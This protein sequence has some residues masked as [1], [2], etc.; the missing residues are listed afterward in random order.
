MNARP[1][2]EN[3]GNG[4]QFKYI[5]FFSINPTLLFALLLSRPEGFIFTKQEYK[6][7][8]NIKKTKTEKADSLVKALMEELPH[9]YHFH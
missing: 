8:K 7:Y 9:Y 3:T 6:I 1:G 5:S 4:K 2:N